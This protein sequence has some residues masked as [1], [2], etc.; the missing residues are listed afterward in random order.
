MHMECDSAPGAWLMARRGRPR[1][2]ARRTKS[3][4]LSRARD[5][6]SGAQSEL[7]A[8]RDLGTADLLQRKAEALGACPGATQNI[9]SQLDS[10]R[11]G[12]LEYKVRLSHA[13]GVDLAYSD[14]AL[15]ILFGRGLI[16]EGQ[17]NAGLTYAALRRKWQA[18]PRADARASPIQDYVQRSFTS[19]TSEDPTDTAREGAARRYLTCDAELRRLSP[20][21]RALIYN[22]CIL[23]Q[24]PGEGTDRAV[25]SQGLE[26][27]EAAL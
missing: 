23:N 7:A 24:L 12:P 3:G 25:L 11:I 5:R 10:Q 9:R 20:A 1:K 21:H 27:L 19:E 17:M 6:V 13:A 14:N 18:F 2:T 22:I 15:G 16:T 26:A 8:I 4:R